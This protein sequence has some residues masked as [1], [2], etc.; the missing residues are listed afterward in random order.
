MESDRLLNLV[1]LDTQVASTG[2]CYEVSVLL[3]F[4]ALKKTSH[5]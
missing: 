5:N 4:L 2:G 1:D 3:N